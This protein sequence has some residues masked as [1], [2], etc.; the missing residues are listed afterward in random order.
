M[1]RDFAA[2]AA[3]H[4][5]I[6]GTARN[7]TDGAVEIIAQGESTALA[8]YVEKLNHGPLLSKVEHIDVAW[9]ELK[10]VIDGFSILY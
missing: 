4:L 9:R 2:R 8:S 5:G 6:T 10:E 1:Y 3:R 7:L